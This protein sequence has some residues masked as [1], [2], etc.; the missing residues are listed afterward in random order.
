MEPGI[1]SR[2]TQRGLV[3][4]ACGL[5]LLV[6]GCGSG[7]SPGSSAPAGTPSSTAS[8]ASPAPNS[9]LCADA[10]DLRAALGKLTSVTPSAGVVDEI[11]ADLERVQAALKTFAA[12]ARGQWGTQV[13][14]L[15]SALDRLKTALGNAVASP[16]AST[17]A[18][19]ATAF[20]AVGTAARNLLDA[21]SVDC[22]PASTPAG[23]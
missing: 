22:P 20:G 14:A 13:E 4:I 23:T 5:A 1:G 6:A 15:Q 18:D 10:A 16:G 2:I 21:V 19:V 11:K 7:T 12:D 17:A 9:A 3:P 8:T